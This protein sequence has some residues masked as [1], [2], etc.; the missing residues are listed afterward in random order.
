MFSPGKGSKDSYYISSFKLVVIMLIHSI[1]SSLVSKLIKNIPSARKTQLNLTRQAKHHACKAV[2]M[3]D[4][5][6]L[7]IE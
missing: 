4:Y 5:V 1:G 2:L 3:K 6:H 7:S